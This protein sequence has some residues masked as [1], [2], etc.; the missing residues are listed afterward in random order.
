M[1]YL[2]LSTFTAPKNSELT[3]SMSTRKRRHGKSRK[4]KSV[5]YSSDD[6]DYQEPSTKKRKVNNNVNDYSKTI[7]DTLKRT[8]VLLQNI[9]HNKFIEVG[10]NSNGKSYSSIKGKL[11]TNGKKQIKHFKHKK[12][13]FKAAVKLLTNKMNNGYTWVPSEAEEEEEEEEEEDTQS[14]SKS[15][16]D[17][18]IT[19]GIFYGYTF[20]MS[21][22]FSMTQTKMETFI[23]NNGGKVLSD[24]DINTDFVIVKN[25]N[26]VL[27]SRKCMAGNRLKIP[28]I[29]EKFL[30]DSIN[31][32][33]IVN[34]KSYII[35]NN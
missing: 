5:K 7:S 31:K 20:S 17:I 12:T 2:N 22:A 6:S 9:K 21:G 18:E 1:K 13:A 3:Y 30:H 11:G 14:S 4:R 28:I 15:S 19:D 8:S 24:P 29:I 26:P 25:N 10:I 16:S 34:Y 35:H 33:E 27:D 23:T 32:N